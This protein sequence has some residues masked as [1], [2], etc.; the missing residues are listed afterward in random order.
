MPRWPLALA[1]DL[2]TPAATATT[3]SWKLPFAVVSPADGE[4]AILEAE[5]CLRAGALGIGEL[6]P[7]GQGFDLGGGVLEPLLQ[8]LEARCVP[9][10]LHV[11]ERVGH[12]YAGKG[13]S[14]PEEAY[15]LAARHPGLRLILSHWGGGLAFYELMPSSRETLANVW[16]D[17]A[18]SPLL[19]DDLIFSQVTNWAP[20]KVVFGTDYPLLAQRRFVRRVLELGVPSERLDA[21]LAGNILKALGRSGTQSLPG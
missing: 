13:Q 6:M 20:T 17:T 16:Y 14:G 18:A 3:M 9:I 10:M 2:A 21:L 1:F 11:S 8:V 15:A 5:R 19:Y 7:D 12:D 4:A